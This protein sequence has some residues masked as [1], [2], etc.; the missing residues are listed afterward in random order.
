M[1]KLTEFYQLLKDI[2]PIE[3][4]HAFVEK[5]A[6]DNSGIIVENSSTVNKALFCLDLTFDSVKKAKSLNCELIVTHHP[7]IYS[8]LSS[9]TFNGENGALLK[10]ITQ[11][12]SIISM[13]LNLDIA[14]TGIDHCLASGLNAKN[15]KIVNK[16][17]G[18]NGY[19]RECQ[20]EKQTFSKFIE[21]IKKTFN[22][23]KI[24]AYGNKKDEIE[25]VCSF[26]GA[27]GDEA[28][29]YAV[30][31]GKA[32]VIVTSDMKHHQILPCLEMGKKVVVIP[33]Y[34]AEEY[35]FRK[36]YQNIKEKINN[37]VEVFYFDD[38]RLR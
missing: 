25:S 13:H 27:G 4:S 2:A 34:V 29:E 1:Y 8:P 12:N 38:K 30:N 32:E 7:V 20:V 11:K 21:S 17:L 10:A 31:G 22:S 23:K 18:E 37:Q 15:Y 9:L 35:G 16:V 26:C 28:L 3:L 5:G 6:F 14:P 24:I 19:G 33:H 36:F